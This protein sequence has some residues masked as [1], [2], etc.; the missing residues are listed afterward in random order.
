MC[1]WRRWGQFLRWEGR[2]DEFEVGERSWDDECM[3]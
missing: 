2:G 3:N 1:L